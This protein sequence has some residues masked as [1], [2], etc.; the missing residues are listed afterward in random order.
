MTNSPRLRRTVAALVVF[1]LGLG[2]PAYALLGLDGSATELTQIL[3]V[4]ENAIS[5]VETART[6]LEV[7]KNVLAL[8]D[9]I[10]QDLDQAM[11]RIG[12]LQQRFDSLS[13]DPAQLLEGGTP[14]N[15]YTD[16][17]GQARQQLTAFADMG[18]D[19]GNSLLTHS[20]QALATAD[21]VS[22]QRYARV[23]RG[24]PSASQTWTQRREQADHRLATD[25]L[26]LDSAERVAELLAS[27]AE[28][29][30][31]SR[32]ATEL[33][34]TALAQEQR[35][36]QLTDI[37]IDIAVAQLTAHH[38]GRNMLDQ[39]ILEREHREWLEAAMTAERDQS[40]QAARAQARV[41]A[42]GAAWEAAW[43]DA[44]GIN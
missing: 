16:F 9:Q 4:A 40:R 36:N 25:M 41:G 3:N 37:E 10:Q 18:D 6:Y 14:P 22:R 44:F 12:A 19:S 20:R 31:R 11:G 30:E 13:S 2:V 23:Y 35:A 38:A 1:L 8:K 43:S 32:Q 34:E 39:I 15:W 33:T 27:A 42:Q 21:T 17:T 26:V 24:I 28:N 7:A 29:V 5:A